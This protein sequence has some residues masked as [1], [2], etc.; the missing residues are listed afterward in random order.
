MGK[1][2]PTLTAVLLLLALA[3]CAA[4]C[5]STTAAGRV[6]VGGTATIGAAQLS[7]FIRDSQ[8]TQS[9][10]DATVQARA[11]DMAVTAS[12]ATQTAVAVDQRAVAQATAAVITQQAVETV[13]ARQATVQAGDDAMS[14]QRSVTLERA[15]IYA[16]QQ[17][18]VAATGTAMV[19]QTQ[20]T[21]RLVS[22]DTAAQR[23]RLFNGA[24]A[25]LIVTF[26]GLAIVGLL[27]GWRVFV[28]ISL[29]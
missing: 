25:A 7:Q 14:T 10:E 23:E 15:H 4:S 22:E 18:Q 28:W 11:M 19:V 1:L 29:F 16:T 26:T 5:D 8:S 24:M 6:T 9:A 13:A 20:T 2:T 21:I 3:A 12:V 27:M 17:A